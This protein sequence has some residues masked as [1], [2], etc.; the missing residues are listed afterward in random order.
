MRSFEFRLRQALAWRRT[1]LTIEE[2]KLQ[3]LTA[4]LEEIRLAAVRV[5][6]AKGRAEQA[7][8][9][10]GIVDAGD[11]WALSA[12]RGRL[13]AELEA[14]AR[15]QRELQQ[16]IAAQRQRLVE[17]ERQ[18]RLLEKLEARRRAEWQAEMDREVESLAAESFLARWNRGGG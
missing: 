1:Q 16:Q 8:R 17:A 11:F 4:G 10:A 18:C 6:L 13:L 3:Q 14:L 12:Y 9:E 5:E 7:V 15:R 2:N